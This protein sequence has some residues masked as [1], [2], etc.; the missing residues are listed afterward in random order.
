MTTIRQSTNWAAG[1]QGVQLLRE[2]RFAQAQV[3]PLDDPDLPVPGR[4]A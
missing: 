2:G 1:V 3:R 4:P